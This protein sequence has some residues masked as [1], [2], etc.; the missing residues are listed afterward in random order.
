MLLFAKVTINLNGK[1]ALMI[2][3]LHHTFTHLNGTLYAR[4]HVDVQLL[5]VFTLYNINLMFMW[6]RIYMYYNICA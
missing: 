4:Y 6:R 2:L 1:M 3:L 5:N